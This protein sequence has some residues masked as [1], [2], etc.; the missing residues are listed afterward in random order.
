GFIPDIAV[1]QSLFYV[2]RSVPQYNVSLFT[3]CCCS[4]VTEP[5]RRSRPAV[6]ISKYQ[7]V[8]FS[9][10]DA[11]EHSQLLGVCETWILLD[12]GD[13]Q[14]RVPGHKVSKDIKG[15]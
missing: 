4:H 15:V 6:G 11:D 9:G 8:I 7:Q 3:C 5:L 1:Q 13:F 12:H 2:V 14:V 10:L